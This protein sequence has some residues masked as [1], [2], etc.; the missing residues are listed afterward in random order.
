MVTECGRHVRIGHHVLDSF[1][2]SLQASIHPSQANNRK[3]S[4]ANSIPTKL[5][6]RLPSAFSQERFLLGTLGW[7]ATQVH[8]KTVLKELHKT[9]VSVLQPMSLSQ[10][11]GASALAV[12]FILGVGSA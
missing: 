9:L 11:D 3:T 5:R 10:E 2:T 1:F 7:Y 8:K 4:G 12:A 6:T